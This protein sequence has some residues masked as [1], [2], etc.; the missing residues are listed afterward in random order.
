MIGGS[1]NWLTVTVIME[2]TRLSQPFV[3]V[4]HTENMPLVSTVI[5]LLVAPLF[6]TLPLM[7]LE[8]NVTLCPEHKEVC[9]PVVIV[10]AGV[11]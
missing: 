7:A 8:V 10:G 3:S 6:H 2:E 5:E 11:E 9:P 4:Y 1:G